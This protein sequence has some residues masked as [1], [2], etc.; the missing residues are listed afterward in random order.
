MASDK[1][2]YENIL[3]ARQLRSSQWPADILTPAK[4]NKLWVPFCQQKELLLLSPEAAHGLALEYLAKRDDSTPLR[5]RGPLGVR[6]AD[7]CQSL[8]PQGSTY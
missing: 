7:L 6:L 4:L 2:S 1:A 5:I 3:R 8:C